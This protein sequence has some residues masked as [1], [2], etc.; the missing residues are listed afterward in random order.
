MFYWKC[1]SLDDV[2]VVILCRVSKFN[3]MEEVLHINVRCILVP[4]VPGL[5]SFY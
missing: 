4:A 5:G 1:Q 2:I 3:K